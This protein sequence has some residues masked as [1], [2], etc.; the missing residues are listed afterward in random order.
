MKIFITGSSGFLG[1]SLL[2]VLRNSQHEILCLSRKNS[3]SGYIKGDIGNLSAWSQKLKEFCPD[4]AIHLAWE[5][6]ANYNATT[7]EAALGN[8][9]NSLNLYRFLGKTGCKKFITM[10]SV[11]E[12]SNNMN[13][14]LASKVALRSF[15]EGI[16]RDSNTQFLWVRPFYI[17]GP[18]QRREAL[19]PTIVS[20]LL[21]NGV[22]EIKN[23]SLRQDFIYVD[24]VA[25][26]I[27][28]IAERSEEKFQIYEIGRGETFLI[29]QLA[30]IAYRQLGFR[31]K[32]EVLSDE[33]GDIKPLV[34][35][36]NLIRQLDWIPEVDYEKGIKEMIDFYRSNAV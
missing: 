5:N 21:N 18:G 27:L 15:G 4:A 29:G 35:D 23:P 13:P 2:K 32:Y 7:P 3:A 25:R 8:F 26:A 6:V 16:S 12:H 19:L 1:K 10:G 34:A 24:D 22:P 20:T 9:I 17:Y 31:E 11:S 30:N 28:K 33:T 36:T 14:F